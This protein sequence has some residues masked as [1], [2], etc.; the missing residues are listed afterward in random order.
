MQYSRAM[1]TY[2]VVFALLLLP[3]AARGQAQQQKAGRAV[4]TDAAIQIDGVLDEPAWAQAPVIS[5]FIQKDPREGEPATEQTEV[6]ILYTKKSIVFGI[7]CND[8]DPARILATELRR[9]NDFANDDSI[10]IL[11]DTLHDHRSAY[12]FRTNPLGTRYDALV[13]DEGRFPDV[14]WDETWYSAAKITETG[15]TVEIEIPFKALRLTGE[16]E[17]TWG[18][19]FERIIRRKS[20]FV[21]W[22][23]YRRSFDFKQVSQAGI[24]RG[25]QDLN[26]GLTLRVKPFTR[27]TVK[28]VSPDPSIKADPHSISTIGL[29][30]VK[31]RV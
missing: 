5:E 28:Q 29:E 30:D 18:L 1:R 19:D 31:Y 24:L 12:L 13:T 7:R 8:S 22:S 20:E 4:L 10:S 15:W 14:N 25:L 3:P 23:N 16:K 26:T 6:R 11:L 9:D 27:T 21:Y 17:Q 2:T